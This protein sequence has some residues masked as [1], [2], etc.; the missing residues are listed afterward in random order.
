MQSGI[1]TAIVMLDFAFASPKHFRS[2]ILDYL[3]GMVTLYMTITIIIYHT[4]ESPWPTWKIDA[5]SPIHVFAPIILLLIWF[6]LHPPA[7][8]HV[9]WWWPLTWMVYPLVF[10]A[11]SIVRGSFDKWYPYGFLNVDANGPQYVAIMVGAL[12][13]GVTVLGYVLVTPSLAPRL[14]QRYRVYK[15][16]KEYT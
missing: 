9:R 11:V 13:V 16:K 15:L 8:Q 1:L 10:A 4:L 12:A 3:R 5:W 2:T 6:W 14:I 7:P